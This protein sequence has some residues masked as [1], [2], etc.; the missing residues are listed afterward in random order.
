MCKVHVGYILWVGVCLYYWLEPVS[1]NF[2]VRATPVVFSARDKY[3][4]TQ[5]H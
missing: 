1:K 3:T 2:T 4:N 5:I